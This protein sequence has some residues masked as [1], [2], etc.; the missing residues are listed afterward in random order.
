VIIAGIFHDLSAQLNGGAISQEHSRS[1]HGFATNGRRVAGLGPARSSLFSRNLADSATILL[2][3]ISPS[4]RIP[5]FG[6][7]DFLDRKSPGN[8][9]E[10]GRPEIFGDFDGKSPLF[11]MV[12]APVESRE[13]WNSSSVGLKG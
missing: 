13:I 8:I 3:D 12:S 9:G 6:S 11:R 1:P 10:A 4:R 7:E 5:S 2:L